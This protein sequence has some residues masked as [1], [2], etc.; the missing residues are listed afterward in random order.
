MKIRVI[1]QEVHSLPIRRAKLLS[2]KTSSPKLIKQSLHNRDFPVLSVCLPFLIAVWYIPESPVFLQKT[3]QLDRANSVW[4]L[5]DLEPPS[6]PVNSPAKRLISGEN[7]GKKEFGRSS[8]P[9]EIYRLLRKPEVAKAMLSG[10]VLM[11][12]FQVRGKGQTKIILL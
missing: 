5:L 7:S 2:H 8:N 6:Q 11:L 3:G 1:S 10:V 9:R 4:K 12:F